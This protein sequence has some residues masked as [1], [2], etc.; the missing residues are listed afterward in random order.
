[1]DSSP[2]WLASRKILKMSEGFFWSRNPSNRASMG[3][4]LLYRVSLNNMIRSE[5]NSESVPALMALKK[6]MEQF[7][8]EFS[9][10]QNSTTQLK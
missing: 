2:Q 10:Q 7:P 3:S 1:M 8:E 6:G 4:N 5:V 9:S